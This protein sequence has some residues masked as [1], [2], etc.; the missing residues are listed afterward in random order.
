M[1][2]YTAYVDNEACA[3]AGKEGKGL[4]ALNELIGWGHVTTLTATSQA[5]DQT[6]SPLPPTVL[7][8]GRAQIV[9]LHKR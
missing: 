3:V 2:D 6:G 4:T 1:Y 9:I 8:E 7:I 5:C